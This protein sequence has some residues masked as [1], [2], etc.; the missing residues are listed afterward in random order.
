MKEINYKPI[1]IIHTPFKNIEGMP[2]Q[3]SGAE[4]VKGVV[5]LEPEYSDGLK[6]IEGFSHIILIFHFH[7]SKGFSLIVKPFI[8]NKR[9]GVFATRA[10]R[11]P[12]QIGI[13]IVKLIKVEGSKLYIENIDVVDGT[14]LLDIKPYIPKFD[15]Q[16]G[17]IKIGW[18]TGKAEKVHQI[19]AD[20]RF[21]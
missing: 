12:N 6:D 21:K 4:G 7:L 18:L 8:D 15:E 1:G 17:N 14:P 20:K 5:E 19:K 10:P 3:P 16:T 9:H 2:I 13:S 11:R